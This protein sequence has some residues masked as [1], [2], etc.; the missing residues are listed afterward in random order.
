MTEQNQNEGNLLAACERLLAVEKEVSEMPPEQRKWFFGKDGHRDCF[1]VARAARNMFK[2]IEHIKPLL[3]GWREAIV[4]LEDWCSEPVRL[5][6]MIAAV[7]Q[8]DDV[9]KLLRGNGH[10]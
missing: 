9:R 8:I 6:N 3:G 4:E 2:Q 10:V 5:K 1:A 7:D